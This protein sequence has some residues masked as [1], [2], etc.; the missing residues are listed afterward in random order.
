MI[1]LEEIKNKTE[2]RAWGTVVHKRPHFIYRS[3]C[4]L[5][6][7]IC[8]FVNHLGEV[9]QKN[10]GRWNWYR[11]PAS[12]NAHWQIKTIEQGVARSKE[13]AMAEVEKGWI[14]I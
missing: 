10:D 5:N 6:D 11:K 8:S 14:L 2:W 4:W 7:T 3:P 12:M 9:S 1:T 13:E